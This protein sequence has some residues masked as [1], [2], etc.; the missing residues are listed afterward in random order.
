MSFNFL[1]LNPSKTEFLVFG[2]PQPLFKFNIPNMY[3]PTKSYLLIYV[4]TEHFTLCV[5][6]F[7][8]YL[9]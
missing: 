2:L 4:K 9:H 7:V 3:L 8:Y 5:C 1:T 6:L